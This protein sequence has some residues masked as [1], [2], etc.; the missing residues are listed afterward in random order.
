MV[1]G[2]PGWWRLAHTKNVVSE[3][4]FERLP[5][6]TLDNGVIK[7][8]YFQKKLWIQN[9]KTSNNIYLMSDKWWAL[10]WIFRKI[11]FWYK[12][13]QLSF[14]IILYLDESGRG[15]KNAIY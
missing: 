9:R 1:S 7:Y 5:E 12:D 10:I 13:I 6:D 3:F 11:H 2:C 4:G 15:K 14:G 8:V